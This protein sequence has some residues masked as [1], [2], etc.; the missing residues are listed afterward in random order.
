ME[1]RREGDRIV[2]ALDLGEADRL[3][4]LL[5]SEALEIQA[6]ARVEEAEFEETDFGRFCLRLSEALRR[7]LEKG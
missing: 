1:A 2:V 6:A 3:R 4:G 5:L 7:L